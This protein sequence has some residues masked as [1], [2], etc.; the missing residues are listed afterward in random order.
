MFQ[1]FETFTTFQSFKS[2]KVSKLRS[3]KVSIGV[4]HSFKFSR[5]LPRTRFETLKRWHF[6]IFETLT[7]SNGFHMFKL[8]NL[9]YIHMC[10]VFGFWNVDSLKICHLDRALPVLK[11]STVH[12]FKYLE[13]SK[14]YSDNAF[15]TSSI[16]R[17]LE[18]QTCRYFPPERSNIFGTRTLVDIVWMAPYWINSRCM[19]G[20]SCIC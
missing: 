15:L 12:S 13:V 1:H 18:L 8:W 5:A 2:V 9:S 7:L 3:F 11:L 19:F 10:C 16:S 17:S 14:L 20:I 6:Q 4:F